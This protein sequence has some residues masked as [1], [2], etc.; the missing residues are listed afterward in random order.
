[1]FIECKG[2][3]GIQ[4]RAASARLSM[5]KAWLPSVSMLVLRQFDH[6]E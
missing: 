5:A 4:K 6:F 2:T 3:T 1:M